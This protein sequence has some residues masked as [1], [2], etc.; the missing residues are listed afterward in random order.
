MKKCKNLVAVYRTFKNLL[1][2]NY[3][4]D[5]LHIAQIIGGEQAWWPPPP[6]NQPLAKK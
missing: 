5:F 1:P 6:L 2:Q 3:S 4:T